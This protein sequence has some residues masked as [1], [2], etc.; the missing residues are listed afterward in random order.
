MIIFEPLLTT[1]GARIFF[2]A[3]GSVAKIG[4]SIK[5]NLSKFN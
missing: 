1:L 4:S 3:V 5:P 2:E